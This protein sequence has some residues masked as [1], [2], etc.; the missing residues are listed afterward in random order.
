[1]KRSTKFQRVFDV[2]CQK[3]AWDPTQVR[4]VFDGTRV[5]GL[6]TPHELEMEDGDVSF[7]SCVLS[8]V[9][10]LWTNQ[11]SLCLLSISCESSIVSMLSAQTHKGFC[12]FMSFLMF[13]SVV[14][15]REFADPFPAFSP[16]LPCRRSMPCLS[17]WAVGCEG[18]ISRIVLKG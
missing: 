15:T 18:K 2:F 8:V 17:K 3:K 12:V 6:Q 5:Q 4:F 16:A 14:I 13:F 10:T 11:R 7:A 1:V 9:A